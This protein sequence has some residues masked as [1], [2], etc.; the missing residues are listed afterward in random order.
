ML[1][2][3]LHKNGLFVI[4]FSV[5]FRTFSH[6]RHSLVFPWDQPTNVRREG[7]KIQSN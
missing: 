2:R 4:L 6:S 7:E 1:L 3:F 5:D